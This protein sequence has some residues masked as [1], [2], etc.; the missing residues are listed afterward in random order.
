[1]LK[2]SANIM[3]HQ[4]IITGS[5]LLKY[6]IASFSPEIVPSFF[7]LIILYLYS[8]ANVSKYFSKTSAL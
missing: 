1:M 2:Q 7:A 5:S 4:V 6:S 8:E 3:S